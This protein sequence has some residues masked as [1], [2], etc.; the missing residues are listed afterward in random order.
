MCI[1][2]VVISEAGLEMEEHHT[3]LLTLCHNLLPDPTLEVRVNVL[4]CLTNL[5]PIL[6]DE[7]APTLKALFPSLLQSV[8]RLLG[9]GAETEAQEAMELF[10]EILDCDLNVISSHFPDFLRFTLQVY[11]LAR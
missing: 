1:L 6:K 10:E 9:E 11:S 7:H 3:N 8:D 2:G 4:K 5:I